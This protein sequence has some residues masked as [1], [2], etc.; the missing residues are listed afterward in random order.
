MSA[1]LRTLTPYAISL[2]LAALLWFQR[3]QIE[4]QDIALKAYGETLQNQANELASLADRITGQRLDLMQLERTQD[5][6]RNALDLRTFDIERLKNENPEVRS[7][8]DSLLP[9]PIARLRERPAITGAAAY[10]EY[11]RTRDAVH[12]AG[13]SAP[14]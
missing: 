6:F 7:W 8:A 14:H 5:E 4:S 10:A 1:I 13:G 9:D 12:P 2:V 3:G 11:L